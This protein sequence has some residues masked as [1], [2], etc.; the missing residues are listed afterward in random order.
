MVA[1][2]TRE[3]RKQF[4]TNVDRARRGERI[5]VLRAGRV[6]AV[7]IGAADYARLAGTGQERK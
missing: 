5:A 7:L 3:I 1:L 2:S 6:E 4:A